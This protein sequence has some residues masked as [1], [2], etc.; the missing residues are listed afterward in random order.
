MVGVGV[1]NVLGGFT[2]FNEM[3]MEHKTAPLTLQAAGYRT[4]LIGK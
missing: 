4:G 3:G 2:R 1:P